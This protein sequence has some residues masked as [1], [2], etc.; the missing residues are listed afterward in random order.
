[1]KPDIGSELRFLP[2]PPGLDAPV[3]FAR[4]RVQVQVLVRWT[5]VDFVIAHATV[6][7]AHSFV[8]LFACLFIVSLSVWDTYRLVLMLRCKS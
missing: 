4:F 6:A 8:F 5:V 7:H 2:T 1:V 3:S